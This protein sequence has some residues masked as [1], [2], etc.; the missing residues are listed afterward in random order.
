[1]A[2]VAVTVESLVRVVLAFWV[3]LVPAETAP[4]FSILPFP[5][6]AVSMEMEPVVAVT[7]SLVMF[8]PAVRVMSPVELLT[9][10]FVLLL[11]MAV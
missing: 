7:I 4:V 10:T 6:V 1:M 11:S 3:M 2:P 8:V 9:V 5:L